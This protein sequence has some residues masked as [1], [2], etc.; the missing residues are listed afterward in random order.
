LHSDGSKIYGGLVLSC[1]RMNELREAC[2]YA[3]EARAQSLV[4]LRM[5]SSPDVNSSKWTL[6]AKT[7]KVQ[8]LE[9]RKQFQNVQLVMESLHRFSGHEDMLQMKRQEAS[10]IQKKIYKIEDKILVADPE[11]LNEF[12]VPT[13]SYSEMQSA[14]GKNAIAVMWYFSIHWKGAFVIAADL[15]QPRVLEYLPQD[16]IQLVLCDRNF[17]EHL[18]AH[19]IEDFLKDFALSLK[20]KEIQALL[21]QSIYYL[22]DDSLSVTSFSPPE[23]AHLIIL[24]HALV[25]SIPLAHL[26]CEGS[27]T[28]NDSFTAGVYTLPSLYFLAASS[29]PH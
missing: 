11:F 16:V 28:L 6:K 9:L 1:I 26:P 22:A 25:S 17:Q 12:T 8:W 18:Q 5:K 15:A 19:K 23:D 27:A 24:P 7:E 29:L 2:E 20:M 14:L 4:E 21:R 3:H 13:M 10:S